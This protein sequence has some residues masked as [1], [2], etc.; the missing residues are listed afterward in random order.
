ME[1]SK[2]EKSPWI[3]KTKING[4]NTTEKAPLCQGK[5]NPCQK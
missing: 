3:K 2:A 4:P 1:K 5:K